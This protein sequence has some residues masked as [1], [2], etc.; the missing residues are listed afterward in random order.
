[1]NETYSDYF[2]ALAGIKKQETSCFTAEEA[3]DFATA[4]TQ[5]TSLRL[6]ET[7]D[8]CGQR[9]KL[10]QQLL[11]ESGVATGRVQI[12]F[13]GITRWT[14]HIAAY[15]TLDTG[16]EVVFDHAAITEIYGTNADISQLRPIPMDEW[17]N[18][19]HD[20]EF[21][22]GEP[23]FH[24]ETLECFDESRVNELINELNQ[25]IKRAYD[26][27]IRVGSDAMIWGGAGSTF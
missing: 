19:W 10:I 8:G 25:A 17:L 15:A 13:S 7:I 22:R 2:T 14:T 1:M 20:K 18:C 12:N 6:D 16:E 23:I 4:L 21:I 27:P 24:R 26:E 9:A 3:Q 11:Q 5:I